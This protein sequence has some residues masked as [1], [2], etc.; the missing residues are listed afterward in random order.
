MG[1]QSLDY[2]FWRGQL[3]QNIA[4]KNSNLSK[5]TVKKIS[6]PS[7]NEEESKGGQPSDRQY[8]G[9]DAANTSNDLLLNYTFDLSLN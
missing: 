1:E 5:V 9:G 7:N 4:G 2:S 6:K 3:E 8:A